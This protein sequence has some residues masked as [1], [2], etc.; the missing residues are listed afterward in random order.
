MRRIA[1]ACV[2]ALS[3]N[4]LGQI[5]S[6]EADVKDMLFND[7]DQSILAANKAQAFLLSAIQYDDGVTAYRRAEDRLERGGKLVLIRRDLTRAIGLF[8]EA[9]KNSA[10]VANLLAQVLDVRADAEAAD[11]AQYSAELWHRA[12][13]LVA[14]AATRVATGRPQAGRKLGLKAVPIYRDAEL[15]SIKAAI[16]TDA[17]LTLERAESLRAHK[18]APEL[19][20]AV[21]AD[22]DAA[23]RLLNRDRYAVDEPRR[24]AESAD[25]LA[26]YTLYVTVRS[27]QVADNEL[28]VAELL[29]EW[30]NSMAAIGE[31]LGVDIRF[32]NGPNSAAQQ[33]TARIQ[34]LQAKP[35]R[36]A[37]IPLN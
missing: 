17:R 11:A 29:R 33:I 3:L 34:S 27:R 18:Y 1:T 15:Q 35:A 32:D 16:L 14:T 25:Q 12:E 7:V 26:S 22:V 30:E 19:L 28:T 31:Q 37:S 21:R 4:G 24:L 36:I 9:T 8:E 5:A 6:V 20:A 23:D 2:V 13:K 10:V